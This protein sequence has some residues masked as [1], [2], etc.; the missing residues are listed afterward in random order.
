MKKFILALATATLAATP[1][2]A[3]P[4]HPHDQPVRNQPT[5]N[6]SHANQQ[7]QNQPAKKAEAPRKGARA[8]QW[9]PGDRFDRNKAVNYRVISNPR[10][11]KLQNAP[12]G[13]RWVQSGRDAVL[14]RLS[15][16]V[17][18]SVAANAIR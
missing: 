6:Y 4:A 15:N 3:A 9:K 5:S 16:N 11:H 12:K 7:G 14:V 2:L 1:V 10:A 17:V 8:N 13:Y 18:S